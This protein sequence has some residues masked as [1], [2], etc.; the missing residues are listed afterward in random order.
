MPPPFFHTFQ[1]SLS[2]FSHMF[3]CLHFF[4]IHIQLPPSH[5]FLTLSS[6][7][8]LFSHTFHC[9]LF[10]HTCSVVSLFFPTSHTHSVTLSVL[11]FFSHTFR[12]LLFS[13]THSV[14]FAIQ[15]NIVPLFLNTLSVPSPFFSVPGLPSP[16]KKIYTFQLPSLF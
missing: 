12:C 7:L 16:F 13:Q 10:Y 2:F 4:L 8:P 6:C 5:L 11:S 15:K 14:A 3:S 9:L 1:L